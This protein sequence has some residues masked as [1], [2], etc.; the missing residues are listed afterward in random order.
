MPTIPRRKEAIKYIRMPLGLYGATQG[1]TI[2]EALGVP[3]RPMM[4]MMIPAEAFATGTAI[5]LQDEDSR[6]SQAKARRKQS[7]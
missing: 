4:G 6:S 3:V 2:S 1:K 7:P 5:V